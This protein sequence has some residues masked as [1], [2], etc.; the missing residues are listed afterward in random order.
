M[1]KSFK[2]K[3]LR[4]VSLIQPNTTFIGYDIVELGPGKKEC[5]SVFDESKTYPYTEEVKNLGEEV[6]ALKSSH[7][8]FEIKGLNP[9]FRKVLLK[10]IEHFVLK[11]GS[12]AYGTFY[13]PNFEGARVKKY[14]DCWSKQG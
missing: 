9:R 11:R 4:F 6:T 10:D 14:G 12:D 7:R 1:E 13:F 5:T 8:D 3:N 2:V